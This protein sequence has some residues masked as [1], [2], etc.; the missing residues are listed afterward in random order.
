MNKR[1]F[2]AILRVSL[3]IVFMLL[4]IQSALM[5]RTIDAGIKWEQKAIDLQ[6]IIYIFVFIQFTLLL[7]V[8]FYVPFRIKTTL[9]SLERVIKSISEWAPTLDM[10]ET[11]MASEKEM[12]PIVEVIDKMYN[13]IHKFDQQKKLKIYE[14]HSRI[15]SIL[16]LADKE[17]IVLTMQGVIAYCSESLTDRYPSMHVDVNIHE[18]TFAPEIEKTVIAYYKEVVN[19]GHTIEEKENYLEKLQKKISIQNQIVRDSESMPIGV[20]IAIKEE[21]K[22]KK[23]QVNN[24][25]NDSK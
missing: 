4:T 8:F 13:N 20:I 5:I 2:T 1:S 22:E 17:F 11:Q 18:T 3:V 25:T 12:A 7:V 10:I 19:S 9:Q 24:Q 15:Q 21:I 23:Q 16:K 6:N 14:Q